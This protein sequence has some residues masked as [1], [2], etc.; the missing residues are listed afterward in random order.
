MTINP[1]WI[2]RFAR[3]VSVLFHPL[4]IPVISLAILQ[5]KT[6]LSDTGHSYSL[7]LGFFVFFTIVLPLLVVLLM[8]KTTRVHSLHLEKREDRQIPLMITGMGFW[9]LF[10]ILGYFDPK[11]LLVVMLRGMILITLA[12]FFI[13][14]F[15]KISIHMAAWGGFFVFLI[16][17][18]NT[19]GTSCLNTIVMIGPFLLLVGVARIVT[20]AHDAAQVLA[21]F[22]VGVCFMWISGLLSA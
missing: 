15:W 2:L 17:L 12:V 1:K 6:G 21:G 8:M 18:H 11:S 16:L 19:E 4:W 20:K 3:F 22:A 14:L 5:S 10:L 9:V 13:S 7:I